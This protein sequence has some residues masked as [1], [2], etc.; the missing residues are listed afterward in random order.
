MRVK[1]CQVF[2]IA[3]QTNLLK[4]SGLHTARSC[5][6]WCCSYGIVIA[7]WPGTS[8]PKTMVLW[9]FPFSYAKRGAGD[10]DINCHL[11]RWI[12]RYSITEVDGQRWAWKDNGKAERSLLLLHRGRRC[13]AVL[14]GILDSRIHF[15][16]AAATTITVAANLAFEQCGSET[17]ATM[18]Y[19]F[20]IVINIR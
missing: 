13:A 20:Y 6:F 1:V 11:L 5:R 2:E 3:N 17:W 16:T 10:F 7:S 4:S 9:S 19:I 15:D 14:K 18:P 8:E 12:L